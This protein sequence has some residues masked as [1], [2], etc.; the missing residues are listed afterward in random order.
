MPG[1]ISILAATRGPNNET[2]S[3]VAKKKLEI[4][5]IV[6]FWTIFS[7]K[8]SDKKPKAIYPQPLKFT[9]KRIFSSRVNK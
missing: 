4:I 7:R 8:F 9:E 2:I 5:E 1:K 6:F 3:A